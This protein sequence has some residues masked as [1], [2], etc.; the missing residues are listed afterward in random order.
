M[1][2][3]LSLGLEKP[4]E[5]MLDHALKLA[6]KVKSKAKMGVY[7]LLRGE[8]WSGAGGVLVN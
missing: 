8:V 5:K 3:N 2:E 6:N 1:Y 4:P 7:G